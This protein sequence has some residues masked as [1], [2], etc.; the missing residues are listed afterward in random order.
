MMR[1]IRLI[2][3]NRSRG[4]RRRRALLHKNVEHGGRA[5][6]EDDRDGTRDDEGP[7]CHLLGRFSSNVYERWS[8]EAALMASCGDK[9]LRQDEWAFEPSGQRSR[10]E[11]RELLMFERGAVLLTGRSSHASWALSESVP[12]S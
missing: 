10:R 7:H 11:P 6:R 4:E 12:R 8:F 9:T 2:E 3:A 5:N 1:P